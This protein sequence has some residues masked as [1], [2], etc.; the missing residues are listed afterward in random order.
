MDKI[1]HK[2]STSQERMKSVFL[3]IVFI[4]IGLMLLP[5]D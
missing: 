4:L 2:P 3:S 5:I 1:S